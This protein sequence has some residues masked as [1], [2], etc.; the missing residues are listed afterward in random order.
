MDESRR[1]AH[2]VA[3]NEISR[4]RERQFEKWGEQDHDKNTWLAILMEEVG[5]AAQA[6]LHDEFGGDHA[7]TFEEEMYHVVAVAVQ[8]LEEI[9]LGRLK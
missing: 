9:Q 3:Q 1:L 6:S 7:G 4:E 2:L 8:I 5:E